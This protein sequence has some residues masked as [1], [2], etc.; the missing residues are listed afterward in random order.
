[1]ARHKHKDLNGFLE[2]W[3]WL[4]AVTLCAVTLGLSLFGSMY[5]G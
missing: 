3:G 5:T 2:K 1:M 4:I